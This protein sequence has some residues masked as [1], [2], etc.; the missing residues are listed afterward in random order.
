MLV[1][2]FAEA[3]AAVLARPL[4]TALTA[5]GTLL[6]IGAL[7][8]TLGLATTA[9]AQIVS[10]F[11]ELAAT[12]VV[13]VPA[14]QGDVEESSSLLPWDAESRVG[15]LRGV[16]AAGTMSE[17]ELPDATIS[18]T[19]VVDPLTRD[20]VAASVVA[21]SPGLL[22][23][24][25]GTVAEGR[26]IDAGNST[27]ADMVAVLGRNLAA[28]LHVA[29]IS[30]QPAVFLDD[31][32]FTVIGVLTDVERN[33]SLLNALIVPDGTA[34]SHLGLTAPTS[35][36]IETRVGAARLITSQ[37]ALA[38]APQDPAR[39]DVT[40][41][42]EPAATRARV[43]ADVQALFL[44]LGAVSLVIGALGIANTTLVSVLERMGEIGLRRS[45]GATR[46]QIAGQFL[47]ESALV[48][49][50]GGILGASIGVLVTVA[51][52]YIRTWTPVLQPWLPPAAMA[53]GAVVGLLAGVYPAWRA[54]NTEPI[55]ALRSD[56]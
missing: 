28:S 23:A 46:T 38:L 13:V 40:H 6:G 17:L 55:A 49:S 25:R 44:V 42:P 29:D 33:P 20:D 27:R 36:R 48:G 30:Q 9:G 43:A 54:A 2:L 12:E 10:R 19:P 22:R 14:E 45:V 31:R 37:A 11:D 52:S 32:P 5:L 51:V 50:L 39:L 26:W 35:V 16:V 24:V 56:G 18:T 53:L 21:A 41:A 34:R 8:A 7:V 15:R 4:R 3:L 1:D 47:V